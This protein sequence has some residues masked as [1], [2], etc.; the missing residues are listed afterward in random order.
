MRSHRL[1]SADDRD[2]LLTAFAQRNRVKTNNNQTCGFRLADQTAFQATET[3]ITK[4]TAWKTRRS[5]K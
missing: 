1:N 4:T 2:R 5:G 3:C